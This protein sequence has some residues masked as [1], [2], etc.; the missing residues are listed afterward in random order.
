MKVH[1]AL[2]PGLLESVYETCLVLELRKRGIRTASQRPLPVNYD[3]ERMD[4]GFR[5]D[6]LVEN[7]EVAEI[8]AV[9]AI[10]PVHMAQVIAYLL[11]G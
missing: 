9:D 3:G 6:I 11:C 7:T 1:T 5:V 8:K 10:N 4:L 2:G